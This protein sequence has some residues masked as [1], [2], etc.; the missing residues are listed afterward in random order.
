MK[1]KPLDRFPLFSTFGMM[2]FLM[3]TCIIAF[4][5][6]FGMMFSPSENETLYSSLHPLSF[7]QLL[8]RLWTL[9]GGKPY[10]LENVHHLVTHSIQAGVLALTMGVCYS[11][12]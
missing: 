8:I 4:I 3:K 6:W 2:L 10:C 11:A 7:F 5:L 12:L 1:M 9:L